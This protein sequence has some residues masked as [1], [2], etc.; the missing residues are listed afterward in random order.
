MSGSVGTTTL[1]SVPSRWGGHRGGDLVVEWAGLGAPGSE[2]KQLVAVE[3]V[4]QL[5]GEGRTPGN[6]VSATTSRNGAT[7]IPA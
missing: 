5:R 6:P 2:A 4:A 1:L 7:K 3:Q